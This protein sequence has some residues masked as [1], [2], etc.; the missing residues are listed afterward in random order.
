MNGLNEPLG[1]HL[2]IVG[3]PESVGE[4]RMSKGLPVVG[5]GHVIGESLQ[6]GWMTVKVSSVTLWHPVDAQGDLQ[7]NSPD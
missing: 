7:W 3:A 6:V 5:G 1:I 2:I 4:W